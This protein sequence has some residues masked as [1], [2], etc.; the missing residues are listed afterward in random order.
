MF[1]K[2]KQILEVYLFALQVYLL[3]LYRYYLL[4]AYIWMH[5]SFKERLIFI[6]SLGMPIFNIGEQ[7]SYIG[8][9]IEYR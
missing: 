7:V 4:K 5:M 3:L 2:G 9:P 8:K 1:L 6:F